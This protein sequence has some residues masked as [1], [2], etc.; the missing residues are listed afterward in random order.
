MR[1]CK[2]ALAMNPSSGQVL[3]TLARCYEAQGH[4]AA[5]SRT[6][7]RAVEHGFT[8][9]YELLAELEL[10]RDDEKGGGGIKGSK[11]RIVRA[12]QLSDR[13]RDDDRTAY[14]GVSRSA[15]DVAG[16]VASAQ[17]KKAKSTTGRVRELVGERRA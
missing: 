17:W 14:W 4:L 11:D 10:R 1:F 9:A 15:A 2:Y 8:L 12:V 7:G 6:A 5:A 3:Y 16:D 13:V